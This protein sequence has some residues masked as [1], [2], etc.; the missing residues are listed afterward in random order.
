M[1][2]KGTA[3]ESEFQ[4]HGCGRNGLA[5]IDRPDSAGTTT[6]I[7]LHLTAQVNVGQLTGTSV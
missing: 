2:A 6:S 4:T 5:R 1:R 7:L 3:R